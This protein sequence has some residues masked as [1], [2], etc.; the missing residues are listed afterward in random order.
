MCW[1]FQL[2][3]T[4]SEPDFG[5]LFRTFEPEEL[6][7]QSVRASSQASMEVGALLAIDSQEEL[8]DNDIE[9]GEVIEVGKHIY[10]VEQRPQNIN[11]G[12]KHDF[13]NIP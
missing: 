11:I 1:C 13:L 6:V 3:R 10:I 2:L 9:E 4:C 5:K 7:S 12:L 8:A